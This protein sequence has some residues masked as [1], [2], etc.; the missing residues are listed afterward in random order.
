MNCIRKSSKN[1]P[2]FQEE[3][4]KSWS[5]TCDFAII[6]ASF[7]SLHS[8]GFSLEW[9]WA[10]RHGVW[11]VVWLYSTSFKRNSRNSR[12]NTRLTGIR[13]VFFRNL[14]IID[15]NNRKKHE[16]R[17]LISMSNSH[18]AGILR[19]SERKSARNGIFAL[20]S[21]DCS[22]F[23]LSGSYVTFRRQWEGRGKNKLNS[24]MM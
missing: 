5:T 24:W 23:V 4:R 10:P 18:L 21:F 15:E 3:K 11:V 12:G 22:T 17:S 13:I 14:A 8:F 7:I 19:V 16:R 20:F 6:C 1:W 9:K 2:I